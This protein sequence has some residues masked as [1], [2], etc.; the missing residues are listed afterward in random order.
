MINYLPIII[1]RKHNYSFLLWFRHRATGICNKIWIIIISEYIVG[2]RG[3]CVWAGVWGGG[4]VGA[5]GYFAFLW[6]VTCS[7]TRYIGIRIFTVT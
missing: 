1:N 2:G 3:V 5:A 6:F 7:A 4:G